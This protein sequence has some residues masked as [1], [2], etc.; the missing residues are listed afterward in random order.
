MRKAGYVL[1]TEVIT[2]PR[3][4]GD[5]VSRLGAPLKL[6]AAPPGRPLQWRRTTMRVQ[7]SFHSGIRP[8]VHGAP[9]ASIAFSTFESS[10]SISPR[11]C[12]ST[13]SNSCAAAV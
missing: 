8:G 2:E 7:L 4:V 12:A 5:A 13:R 1:T 9:A 10:P 3:L 6:G 11:N